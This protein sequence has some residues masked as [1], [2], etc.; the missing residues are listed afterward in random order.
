MLTN[1]QIEDVCKYYDIPLKTVCM[2]DELKH[3]KAE[4]GYYIVNLQSST[5]GNG[6]HWLG[7]YLDKQLSLFFDSFGA[8]C[9]IEVDAFVKRFRPKHFAYNIEIIQD[10]DSDVCG[11]YCI[12]LS[13]YLKT[14]QYSTTNNAFN[15]FINLF[16]DDTKDNL[17]VLKNVF[18][19]FLPNKKLH[20]Q[21]QRMY[22]LKK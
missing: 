16:R 22:A 20:L 7:L 14:H 19:R 21:I 4:E 10:L 17:K 1:F 13:L 8:G 2:K 3:I 18:H 11:Y 15:S 6:S 9:P 5:D 12:A